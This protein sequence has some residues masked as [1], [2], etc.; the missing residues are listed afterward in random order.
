MRRRMLKTS[1]LASSALLVVACAREAEKS[2]APTAPIGALQVVT[3]SS[4]DV[5]TVKRDAKNYLSNTDPILTILG[6]LASALRGTDV[7]LINNLGFDA[8][9]RLAEA[10]NLG[11]GKLAADGAKTA[12]GILQCEQFTPPQTLPTL[13]VLT[14][15]FGTGAGGGIIAVRGGTGDLEDAALSPTAAAPKWGA[16]TKGYSWLT[17]FGAR[18]FV[19][20]YRVTFA[21]FTQESP[22]LLTGGDE[23]GTAF[24]L[25]T[26]PQLNPISPAK[27]LVGVCVT[28]DDHYRIQHVTNILTLEFPAF[29]NTSGS[30]GAQT[31]VL[32]AAYRVVEW[33]APRPL[34]AATMFEGLGTGSLLSG[35]SPSGAVNLSAASIKLTIDPIPDIVVNHDVDVTVHAASAKGNPVENVE[36]V[37]SVAGNNGLGSDGSYVLTGVTSGITDALGVVKLKPFF[38]K[39][40]AYKLRAVGFF[41]VNETLPTL[42]ALS[43]QFN[44]RGQ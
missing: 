43:N 29:C 5:N 25:A 21:T 12:W 36:I 33:L 7:T 32:A 37:V 26:F 24:E 30:L 31:G 9:R 14:S 35:L 40:G 19:Y 1:F 15:A 11:I 41:N 18:V 23:L 42:A 3:S 2:A 4:C 22:A 16:E 20:G 27:L 39:S 34:Y 17:T 44:I 13:A 6:D 38:N 10:R 8:L 28:D